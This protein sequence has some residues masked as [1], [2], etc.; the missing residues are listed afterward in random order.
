ML[1]GLRLYQLLL[2]C[3]FRSSADWL[4]QSG[5]VQLFRIFHAKNVL[6]SETVINTVET[7]L[8]D[9]S[10]VASLGSFLVFPKP[11]ATPDRK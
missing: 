7:V 8:S 1:G 4:V 3:F 6:M 9:W 2:Y 11:I 5:A 10:F